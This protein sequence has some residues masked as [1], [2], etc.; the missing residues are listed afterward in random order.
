MK[1]AVGG[2]PSTTKEGQ[3]GLTK[4][5]NTVLRMLFAVATYRRPYAPDEYSKLIHHI[6]NALKDAG[7]EMDLGTIRTHWS[8]AVEHADLERKK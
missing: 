6:D 4:K 7:L 8:A 3:S 5:Y 2:K 1:R